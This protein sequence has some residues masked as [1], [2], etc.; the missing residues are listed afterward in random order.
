MSFQIIYI[1]IYIWAP[2]NKNLIPNKFTKMLIVVVVDSTPPT[3]MVERF[4][5]HL[6]T[7]P[8]R[9]PIKAAS[10]QGLNIRPLPFSQQTPHLHGSCPQILDLEELCVYVGAVEQVCVCEVG[11]DVCLR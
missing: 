7:L 10:R 6:S 8:D 2:T 3:I 9:T 4:D 5:I 1:Y 11:T